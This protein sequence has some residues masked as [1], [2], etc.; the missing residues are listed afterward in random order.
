MRRGGGVACLI[1]DSE[2]LVQ[3]LNQSR[4]GATF[5]Q[6][7]IKHCFGD[8]RRRKAQPFANL[9][10]H[11]PE[12]QPVELLRFVRAGQVAQFGY[13]DVHTSLHFNFASYFWITRKMILSPPPY[14]EADQPCQWNHL[15]CQEPTLLNQ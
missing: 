1:G 3:S 12:K 7:I 11:Q 15:N 6:S 8:C 2:K 14:R 9:F 5:R 4:R 13:S 10:L